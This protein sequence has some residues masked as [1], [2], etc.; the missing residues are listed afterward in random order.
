MLMLA[1][2]KLHATRRFDKMSLD[3]DEDEHSIE[4]QLPFLK[5]I[6]GDRD[7]PIVPILVGNLSYEGECEYGG[8]LQDFI[9]DASN[10]FVLSSDFCHWGGRF[11]YKYYHAPP[12]APVKSLRSE[13][14]LPIQIWESIELMDKEGIRMVEAQSHKEFSDYL[15]R[16]KNTI[17]GRHPIGVMLAALE[18]TKLPGA[19]RLLDYRQSNRVV[20]ASDGSVSYV[21]EIFVPR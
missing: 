12:E 7:L 10:A 3:V 13:K 9:A 17:C 6:M 14:N 11:N 21:S 19:W 15:V 18:R 20:Q 2:A 8:L 4:M 1:I 16:T 5:L